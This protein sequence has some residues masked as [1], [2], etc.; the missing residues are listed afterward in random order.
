ML[1]EKSQERPLERRRGCGKEASCHF[2]VPETDVSMYRKRELP[3]IGNES[4]RVSETRTSDTRNK[5]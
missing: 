5:S 3:G 1:T 2:R 4:F